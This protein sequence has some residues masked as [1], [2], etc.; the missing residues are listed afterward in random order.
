MFPTGT[1][2]DVSVE[3]LSERLELR[4]SP[5]LRN[6]PFR[7]MP[8]CQDPVECSDQEDSR[9]DYPLELFQA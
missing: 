5:S 3:P 8:L 9:C 1:N 6:R 2:Q 4:L 7:W